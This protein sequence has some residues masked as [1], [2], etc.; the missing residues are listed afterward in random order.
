M[1]RFLEKEVTLT[2]A[3]IGSILSGIILMLI[4]SL[5][6]NIDNNWKIILFILLF[7]ILIIFTVSLFNIV[8]I[9]K[10]SIQYKNA[11][12]TI[13]KELST[14]YTPVNFKQIEDFPDLAYI[15]LNKTAYS[16]VSRIDKNNI[17]Y[18]KIENEDGLV[19]DGTT[20]DY[21]WFL[22]NISF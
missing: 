10:K 11:L 22:E 17:I 1:K 5:V 13:K 15:I 20:T 7:V 4:I 2:K 6:F 21:I 12:K 14:K 16:M 9:I 8:M 18:L 19:F 3:T